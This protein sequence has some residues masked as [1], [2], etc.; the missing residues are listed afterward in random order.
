M[1]LGM[2]GLGRMG[3]NMAERLMR[4][5]HQVVAYDRDPAA[6]KRVGGKGAS[7]ADSLAAVAGQLQAPRAVWIMV[8]SGDPVDQT[9][10][11]LKPHLSSGDV[12]LDG[13]NSNYKDTMRRASALKEQGLDF[14]DVGTSGG[15]WGLAE[16]YSMMIGGDAGVVERLNPI[17]KTLAPAPDK[18]WGRVGPSGSGHFVKMVHNGIEYGLMQAYAEGFSLMERKE[19]FGLDLRQISEI[20]R[21]GSV[22]RSWLLDLTARALKENPTLK[23]IA[24]HVSDS[25][26]GRWTVKEAI[27]LRCSIPVIT[28]A[29]QRRFRSRENEPF[30]D[31]LLAVMRQQFGGH[32]VK[33]E[34]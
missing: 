11:A 29:L 5:G 12:I 7:G 32:A 19:E 30:A 10:E 14:V 4:G 2:I 17:F 8:P 24:A 33:R 25:G 22:V 21:Y 1:Q 23:G 13:G 26:E 15:V 27:D 20:W 28:L 31:K 6:T 3:A 34:P 16:G 9:I 18:G